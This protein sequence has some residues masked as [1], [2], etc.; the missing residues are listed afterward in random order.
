MFFFPYVLLCMYGFIIIYVLVCPYVSVTRQQDYRC[1]RGPAT[2]FLLGRET[3]TELTTRIGWRINQNAER[4]TALAEV[5]RNLPETSLQASSGLHGAKLPGTPSKNDLTTASHCDLL[6]IILRKGIAYS[7]THREFLV[8]VRNSWIT[9]EIFRVFQK[10][11]YN[12]EGLYKFIHRT[13]AVF[14]TVIM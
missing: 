1:W 10:E 4:E 12:F 3:E 8:Y 5:S 7:G 11:L 13:W 2:I 9:V 6:N 14:R